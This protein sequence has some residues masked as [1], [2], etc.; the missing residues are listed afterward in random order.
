MRTTCV[1]C[2]VDYDASWVFTKEE[3]LQINEGIPEEAASL[4]ETS[5]F[6][7][8]VEQTFLLNK[9][10]KRNSNLFKRLN[11]MTRD[12]TLEVQIIAGTF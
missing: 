7:F 11:K 1:V 2:H 4:M 10:N 8:S 6:K 12:G 9:I 5:Y 3:C